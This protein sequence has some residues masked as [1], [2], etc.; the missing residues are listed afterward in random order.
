MA[1]VNEKWCLEPDQ[2]QFFHDNGYLLIRSLYSYEEVIQMRGQFHQ[3]ITQTDNRPKNISYSFMDPKESYEIDP[4]NPKN[5]QGMMDHVLASDFWFD[6]FTD[7]RIISVMVDLLG[8]NIDFHN[9]K[10]RNKPPGFYSDQSWHQDWPYERHT[11][12]ELAAAI[13]YLDDTDFESGAT[14]VLPESHLKGEWDTSDG[15]RIPD[16]QVP[17]EE[18]CVLS[19]NAGDVAIVHVLAVHRAGHNFTNTARHAIINEYKTSETI[20]QWNN[21]CAFAGL[22]LARNSEL[23]MPRVSK[24]C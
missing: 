12:P 4:F 21:R 11:K 10:V 13:T 15:Y 23:L 5:V 19:A 2:I 22:P 17:L 20:D 8:P 7:P 1:N 14:E 24:L 3:L 6:H 18:H 9:G 16:D